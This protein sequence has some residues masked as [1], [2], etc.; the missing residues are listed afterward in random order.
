MMNESA[1]QMSSFLAGRIGDGAFWQSSIFLPFSSFST[2]S[3]S[4]LP[5]KCVSDVDAVEVPV[6]PFELSELLL[7]ACADAPANNTRATPSSTALKAVRI[8]MPASSARDDEGEDEAEERERL[9]ERDTEE[10]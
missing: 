6:L 9:G 3:F 7:C 10:H 8:R 4:A 1:P 2:H 5:L